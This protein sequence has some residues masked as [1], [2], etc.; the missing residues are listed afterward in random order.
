MSRVSLLNKYLI[1][2]GRPNAYFYIDRKTKTMKFGCHFENCFL[3]NIAENEDLE[4]KLEN[5]DLYYH[6]DKNNNLCNLCNKC[7]YDLQTHND[8][9][10]FGYC[11]VVTICGYY[12]VNICSGLFELYCK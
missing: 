5:G 1:N 3:K 9:I 10:L 6:K 4:K 8:R 7:K 11:I 2:N 12:F